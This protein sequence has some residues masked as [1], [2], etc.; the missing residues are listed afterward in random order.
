M[1]C[2]KTP[3]A[4][5]DERIWISDG[6]PHFSEHVLDPICFTDILHQSYLTRLFGLHGCGDC[7]L[8]LHIEFR[9]VGKGWFNGGYCTWTVLHGAQV[10]AVPPSYVAWLTTHSASSLP[11]CLNLLPDVSLGKSEAKHHGIIPD[12]ALRLRHSHKCK[13]SIDADISGEAAGQLP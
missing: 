12:R 1:T 3:K 7:G 10:W 5:Q 4:K 2:S 9:V 11:V 6:G 8:S 13:F